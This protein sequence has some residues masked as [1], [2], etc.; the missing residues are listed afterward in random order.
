MCNFVCKGC[1][2][3]DLYCVGWDIKPYLLIHSL[4]Y[5]IYRTVVTHCFD[6]IFTSVLLPVT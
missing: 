3:N 5:M 1:P 6:I 4:S 2:R